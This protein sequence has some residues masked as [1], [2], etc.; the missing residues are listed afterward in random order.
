MTIT[1]KDKIHQLGHQLQHYVAD[2][3]INGVDN[4]RLTKFSLVT[5]QALREL[6]TSPENTPKHGEPFIVAI[7]GENVYSLE[8]KAGVF[9]AEV[10]DL[11]G[12]HYD[13]EAEQHLLTVSFL[14][15]EVSETFSVE[16][17]V[18]DGPTVSINC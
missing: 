8:Y 3:I 11:G 4:D 17:K 2:F 15:H 6:H 10:C 12:G 9:N 14:Y 18:E 1:L 16:F 5:Q 7:A 13:M